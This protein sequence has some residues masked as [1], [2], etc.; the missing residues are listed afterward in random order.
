MVRC[1]SF[2]ILAGLVERSSELLDFSVL[3]R[4]RLHVVSRRSL[5]LCVPTARDSVFG[6]FLSVVVGVSL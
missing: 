4:V 6:F 2:R 3:G 1:V 5:G